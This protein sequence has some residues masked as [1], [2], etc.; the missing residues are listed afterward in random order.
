[1]GNHIFISYA[2]KD[3]DFVLRLA[4]QLKSRGAPVWLDQWNIPAGAHWNQSID[5]A[6][7]DCGQ[8]M[9]IL[10]PTAVASQ[11]VQGELQMALDEKKPIV[12]VL[13]Q[14]CHVPRLLRLI[15]HIDFTG[16]SPDDE[17]TLNQLASALRL[18]AVG[19][20]PQ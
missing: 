9:I 16:C 5:S 12:P 4:T 2:R 3:K 14:A 7:R 1:M 17:M 10:S 13:R 18:P 20:L 19:Y 8:F 15:Q 11:Q 6:L